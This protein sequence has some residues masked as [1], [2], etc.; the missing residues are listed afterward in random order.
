MTKKTF[1]LLFALTLAVTSL[2]V[3]CSNP[4]SPPEEYTVTFDKNGGDTE[5]SPTTK[6]VTGSGTV[7]LPTEPK[8]SGYIFTGWNKEQDGKGDEFTGTTRVAG[9]I[10]VYAQW[11]QTAT[12]SLLVTFDKNGGDTD[13]TPK[14]KL[15]KS[16]KIDKLPSTE[17]TKA[18]KIFVG[19]FTEKTGG[20]QF[21]ATTNVTSS[22]TV[23]ARWGEPKHTITFNLNGGTGTV[24]SIQVEAGAVLTNL[25]EP[26]PRDGY[27]F[28]GW[29]DAAS[30]GTPYTTSSVMPNKDLTLFAQWQRDSSGGD[31]VI[32]WQPD[33]TASTAMEGSGEYIGQF[34]IQRGAQAS[35]LTLAAIANGFTATLVSGTYKQIN[36]QVGTAVGGTD[37]YHQDGFK[38]TAGTTYTITFMASASG[39]GQLR[40]NA[41]G[42]PSGSDPWDK[43]QDLTTTPTEFSYTWTQGSGNLVL[44]TGNTAVNGVITITGIKI[45][46]P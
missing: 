28:K 40:A 35:E 39:T 2:F 4:S 16:G 42:A 22:I 18:G 1:F 29:F 25:P 12:G 9:N 10:T 31:A 45:T 36:I 21:L 44:D 43:T 30:G 6:T 13:A 37:Y 27:T 14:Q 19:W 46:S 3:A 24:D 26:A 34:G 11:E 38:P 5:A 33:I 20:T 7:T 41:N 32:V 23:Y 17:P 15:V 8:K